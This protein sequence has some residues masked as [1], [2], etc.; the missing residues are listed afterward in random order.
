MKIIGHGRELAALEVLADK[1][2]AP[3]A[4]I[5]GGPSALGKRL[6]ARYFFWKLC[7]PTLS[8]EAFELTGL[9]ADILEV[10]PKGDAREI[11]LPQMQRVR[12]F[13]SRTPFQLPA[14]LV[15]IDGAERMRHEAANSLLKV[16]EEPAPNTYFILVSESP[17]RILATLR[18]RSTTVTFRHVPE[19]ELLG[20]FSGKE[21]ALL[22]KELAWIAGRPGLALRFIQDPK[23]PELVARKEALTKFL[24]LMRF[25]SIEGCMAS[26]ELLAENP[27]LDAALESG[28]L[29]AR[30]LFLEKGEP[31]L[32]RLARSRAVLRTIPLN[33]RLAIE[34]MLLS[35]FHPL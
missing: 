9:H 5:F 22:S 10:S 28:L 7:N 20:H 16:L 4:L 11:L 33:R 15:I 14:K 1:E 6:A 35:T 27:Q 29:A 26:A 31:R 21:R 17:R 3:H 34:D 32:K 24:A 19:V 12:Q 18:S 2:R 23:N 30:V 13:V 25:P 8:R